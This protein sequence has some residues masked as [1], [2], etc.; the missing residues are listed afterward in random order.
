VF[1]SGFARRAVVTFVSVAAVVYAIAMFA[2]LIL[3]TEVN[4]CTWPADSGDPLP[5][6]PPGLVPTVYLSLGAGI[7]GTIVW[8]KW[9]LRVGPRLVFFVWPAFHICWVVPAIAEHVREDGWGAAFVI[10]EAGA[11]ALWPLAMLFFKDVRHNA[12]WSDGAAFYPDQ[13]NPPPPT[14]PAE[15]WLKVWSLGVHLAGIAMG[16]AFGFSVFASLPRLL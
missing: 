11:F 1:P 14:P 9:G 5:P 4:D 8:V 3:T 12:F 6:C 16:V 15:P 10:P 2:Q 13:D 7:V